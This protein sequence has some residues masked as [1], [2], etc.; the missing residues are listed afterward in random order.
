MAQTAPQGEAQT[1]V[2]EVVVSG[3]RSRPQQGPEGQAHQHRRDRRH[4]G[5]GHRRLPRPGIWPRPSSACR[6]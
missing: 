1:Q 4:P 6:A 3:Y 5:R 2:E